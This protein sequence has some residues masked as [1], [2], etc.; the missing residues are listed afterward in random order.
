MFKSDKPTHTDFPKIT[1]Y[2]I[3]ILI[4]DLFL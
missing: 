3:P 1:I 2:Q 4:T